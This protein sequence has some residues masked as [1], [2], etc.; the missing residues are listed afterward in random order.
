LLIHGEKDVVLP[1]KNADSMF[2]AASEPKQF[3]RLKTAGHNDTC[4]VDAKLFA[5]TVTH[6]VAALP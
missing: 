1:V 4:T 3:L 2:A 6:F 5:N